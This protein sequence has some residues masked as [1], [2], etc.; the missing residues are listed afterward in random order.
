M[1]TALQVVIFLTASAA[2]PG[3]GAGGPFV[4]PGRCTGRKILERI[5]KNIAD[6]GIEPWAGAWKE[7]Q[8]NRFI[9]K[10]YQPHPLE[11]VG[12]GV[13]SVG[14][15]NVSRDATAA[16]YD[17][18]AWSI[19][20]DEDYAKK[21]IEILNAWSSTCKEINGKDA[22]LC[23]GIYGYKLANAAEIMRHSYKKWPDKEV[24][25]FET[26]LKTVV[27]PVIKDFAAL[28][29]WKLGRVLLAHHDVD[30]HLLRRP[31]SVR[32]RRA[33]LLAGCWKWLAWALRN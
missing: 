13:G 1:A 27:Y 29:Q 22:V 16:Y 23:A 17:A 30:R 15:Q 10:A 14:M 20:G 8:R 6:T 28:R 24:Q 2:G 12:R 9:D 11:I 21:S 4:H 31:A 7:F 19:T 25:R 3:A 5:R 32:S 33:R 18:L 26:W